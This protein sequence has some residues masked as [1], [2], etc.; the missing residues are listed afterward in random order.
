MERANR[1]AH[2]RNKT[3]GGRI[4]PAFVAATLVALVGCSPVEAV[5]E[6]GLDFQPRGTESRD[7]RMARLRAFDGKVMVA[8]W[9]RVVD[10]KRF[11]VRRVPTAFT[12]DERLARLSLSRQPTPA[13]SDGSG[14]PVEHF[15]LELYESFSTLWSDVVADGTPFVRADIDASEV[16]IDAYE[17]PADLYDDGVA[18]L[19]IGRT[20]GVE[21]ASVDLGDGTLI[22]TR[23]DKVNGEL[24][25]IV[26]R[27][28]LPDSSIW[29]IEL[30][31]QD[32]GFD[33][34]PSR[35]ATPD[36]S[37]QY[38]DGCLDK[39]QTAVGRSAKVAVEIA[40]AGVAVYAATTVLPV[41][42]TM[43][44]FFPYIPAARQMTKKAW[45]TLGAAATYVWNDINDMRSAITEAQQAC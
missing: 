23:L 31:A 37:D 41:T 22:E 30:S 6:P 13:F 19:R 42:R 35:H 26:T 27:V 4:R 15:D 3:G 45:T 43:T 25:S 28:Q 40:V 34:E 11:L 20:S 8:T 38:A 16:G 39:V 29:D 9:S 18:S 33:T 32:L 12:L 44:A 10:G 14:N 24:S 5:V 7:V 2:Q 1:R 17:L 21:A 36:W